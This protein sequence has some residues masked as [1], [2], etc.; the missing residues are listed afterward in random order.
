MLAE[1]DD[2]VGAGESEGHRLHPF[3]Q[4]QAV[5]RATDS[6]TRFGRRAGPAQVRLPDLVK[7]AA[8]LG[9]AILW[10]RSPAGDAPLRNA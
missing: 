5:I 8:G 2:V 6:R 1:G 9:M 7:R 10:G 4:A 3:W